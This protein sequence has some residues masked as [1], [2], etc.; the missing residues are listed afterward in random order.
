[1]G[2][3]GVE[4]YRPGC[5]QREVQAIRLAYLI[6][7]HVCPKVLERELE[8]LQTVVDRDL[9]SD[10]GIR[11]GVVA[12]MMAW[13]RHDGCCCEVARVVR[14]VVREVHRTGGDVFKLA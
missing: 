3:G 8:L 7:Q 13:S 5:R 12:D 14:C 11:A 9:D 6:N 1:M 2:A 4:L 10:G